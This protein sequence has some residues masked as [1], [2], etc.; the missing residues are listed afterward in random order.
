MNQQTHAGE[1]VQK[2]EV[3]GTT[4]RTQ[5]GTATKPLNYLIHKNNSVE[6]LH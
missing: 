3:F 4:V 2:G 6:T 1:D 5:T